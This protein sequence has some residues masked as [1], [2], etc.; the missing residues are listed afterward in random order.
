[1]GGR[2]TS[3]LLYTLSIHRWDL[4]VE[5]VQNADGYPG[6]FGCNNVIPHAKWHVQTAASLSDMMK[7]ADF[8]L[9]IERKHPA[10]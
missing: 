4:Y 10:N 3:Y 7:L 6:S 9:S 5:D 8:V 2:S 1:M